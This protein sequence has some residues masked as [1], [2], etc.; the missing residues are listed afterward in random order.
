MLVEAMRGAWLY[1]IMLIKLNNNRFY[2]NV[3]WL[4]ISDPFNQLLNPIKIATYISLNNLGIYI[5]YY[6]ST[7]LLI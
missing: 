2:S 6:I 1:A 5:I 7:R 4:S 3:D